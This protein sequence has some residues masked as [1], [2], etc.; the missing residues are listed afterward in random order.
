M[1][2]DSRAAAAG[3]LHP[4]RGHSGSAGA[5]ARS[6]LSTGELAWFKNSCSSTGG[7]NCIEGTTRSDAVH[8]RDSKDER[9][10]SLSLPPESDRLRDVCGELTRTTE[11]PLL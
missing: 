5:N 11:R 6:A 10:P 9:G 4:T 1:P 7:D 3:G 2:V 8:V